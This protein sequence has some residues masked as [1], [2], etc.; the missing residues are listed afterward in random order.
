MA[1]F[2]MPLIDFVDAVWLKQYQALENAVLE[3]DRLYNID[4]AEG[5]Q[6]DDIGALVKQPRLG[7][8]DATYRLFIK[9][10]ALANSTEGRIND[11]LYAL[12]LLSG[13]P[14]SWAN[15]YTMAVDLYA[16]IDVVRATQVKTFMQEIVQAGVK[17]LTVQPASI[18]CFGFEGSSD[19]DTF[20]DATDAS[21]GGTF[22][23]ILV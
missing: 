21:V 10:R 16:D 19:S 18:G 5:V 3:L 6:L 14:S 23:T 12:E 15:I 17:I 11:I 1:S 4:I 22:S 9:A 13:D 7:L 8:D 20:G 2:V